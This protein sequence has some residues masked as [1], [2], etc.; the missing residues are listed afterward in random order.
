MKGT[1]TT[2]NTGPSTLDG[3]ASLYSS[4]DTTCNEFYKEVDHDLNPTELYQKIC[5]EDWEGALAAM[6]RNPLECRTWVVQRDPC[7]NEEEEDLY[8]DDGGRD[9]SV[10]FL[11]LHSACAR[12]PPLDVVTALLTSYPEGVAMVDLNGMFALHYACENQASAAV[13]ELLLVRNQEANRLPAFMN[14]GSLPIH[15]A[16]QWGVSSPE[17][18]SILLEV[19]N[20]LAC[21]KDDDG[22]TP[23]DLALISEEYDGREEVIDILR[24]AVRKELHL[25]SSGDNNIGYHAAIQSR[26]ERRTKSMDSCD[27]SMSSMISDNFSTTAFI[28]KRKERHRGTTTRTTRKKLYLAEQMMAEL[29]AIREEIT[30]RKATK[31]LR[32]EGTRKHIEQEWEAVNITLEEME[33]QVQGYHNKNSRARNT[34]NVICRRSKPSNTHEGAESSDLLLGTRDVLSCDS[35]DDGEGDDGSENARKHQSYLNQLSKLLS[36]TGERG[37]RGKEK[38]GNSHQLEEILQE[39]IKMRAEVRRLAEKRDSYEQQMK[40][41]EQVIAEISKTVPLMMKKNEEDDRKFSTMTTASVN[42]IRSASTGQDA[43]KHV[44]KRY[45]RFS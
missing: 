9:E 3:S 13:I 21:V 22:F 26:K 7:S 27:M 43:F 17:V 6:E 41:M 23:L 31:I 32:E 45:A 25:M 16:A 33:R 44:M 15:L 36:S 35:R 11:P 37:Q 30:D 8:D 2:I 34:K 1:G 10:R 20:D 19:D 5:N 42:T 24:N 18:M 29:D 40:T 38:I 28:P 14:N 4:D 12:K 39:N